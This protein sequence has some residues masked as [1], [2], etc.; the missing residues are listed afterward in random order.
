MT[1]AAIK[2]LLLIPLLVPYIL[3]LGQRP[4]QFTRNSTLNNFD[5]PASEQVFSRTNVRSNIM[6]LADCNGLGEE[7]KSVFFKKSAKGSECHGCRNIYSDPSAERLPE[8]T[9][10]IYFNGWTN[11]DTSEETGTT[12][13]GN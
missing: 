1:M 10:S 7:C 6:C 5:C 3:S 8:W 11:N 9:G 4:R 12:I 13:S 2:E